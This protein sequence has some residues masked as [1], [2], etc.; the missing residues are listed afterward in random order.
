MAAGAALAGSCCRFVFAANEKPLIDSVAAACKRLAPLGWRSMMLDVT[1]GELDITAVDLRAQLAKTLTRI[2]RT[3]PGFGDFYVAGNRGIEVGR[4]N[5]SLLYHAFAAPTVVADRQGKS[6]DGFPTLAEI[7]AVENYVYGAAPP[8][9]EDLRKL[10]PH[11]SL[12]IAVFA[13]EYRNTPN[14]VHGRHAELCFSRAGVARL[15]TIGP[16]YNDRT[17]AFEGVDPAQ[18]FA[19]CAV[20]QRFAA[21]LAVRMKGD[22]QSFG[23][24]DFL[25]ADS[26]QKEEGDARRLFWVPVH[27]LF[28]GPECISGHTLNLEVSRDLRNDELARFHQFLDTG[29]YRNNW[30]GADLENYPFTIRNE[31]IASFSKN[32]A[33][34]PG[35]IEPTPAPLFEAAQ[36]QGKPLT[37]PV[38]RRY[39]RD[40]MNILFSSMQ[41]LPAVS[42]AGSGPPTYY[43]DRGADTQ[44]PAP[45]YLN[46]RHRVLP[47][48]VVDDL[49]NDPNLMTI[50]RKGGY[51]TL[52]YIDF[53]GDGWIEARCAALE[54]EVAER[55]PAYCMVGPPDFY[56]KVR[57]RELM[58]WWQNEVPAV[59]RETLWP[60]PPLCLSQTRIAANITLPIGFSINDVTVSAIVTQPGSSGGPPQ[61]PNGPLPET[62]TGL[63]DASPG[64]FDPGWDV[65][66]GIYFTDVEA[67]VQKFLAGY[68]LGSPFV[69]DAKLCAALGNYWPGIS[70]DST[71]EFQPDKLLGGVVYPWPTN[72]PMTDEEI[73]IAPADV[74]CDKRMPWD[75]VCGPTERTI[76]GRR[77]AAYQ[78]VMRVDYVDM[79]GTMTAALTSRVTLAEY[80]ARVLAMEAVYW[81]L[82]IRGGRYVDTIREKAKWAVRS[83]RAVADDDPELA[84]AEQATAT[85]LAGP[86]RYRF[87]VF[88]WRQNPDENRDA[89][90]PRIVLIE[91]AERVVLYVAGNIVLF[92]RDDGPWRLD[93]SM[94]T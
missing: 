50:I 71:R 14:S 7:D 38:D 31:K 34:G 27:K 52:H 3:Y 47:D 45:E 84:K 58:L 56:P 36:Y 64:I 44:R 70:P 77:F 92:R 10:Y 62:L 42:G 78:D 39:M 82:G 4:P 23:P 13:L 80:K 41:V 93:T 49:N 79:P 19:F 2:D 94:P 26:T 74:P 85:K 29:G 91:M 66:Q 43:E 20:P 37:F 86:R 16:R 9:L 21:Y 18:P 65:S 12:A 48:G 22:Y 8:S 89:L 51:D 30:R 63:P 33:F 11:H 46:V 73:G 90:N 40:P 24:Q 76:D 87:E 15:G 55:V 32:P 35:V 72:A 60:M 59:L 1:G 83:F 25:E 5:Q 75:G 67:P 17:R 61:T 69:E 88:R 57:Q 54:P 28:N 6:L 68:G 53:T 81:S